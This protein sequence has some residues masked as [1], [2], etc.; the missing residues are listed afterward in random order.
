M[1]AIVIVL[2]FVALSAVG[3]YAASEEP[4]ESA[5]MAS[6]DWGCTG[7]LAV[8]PPSSTPVTVS[9]RLNEDGMVASARLDWT[10]ST[11]GEYSLAVNL[12]S[13]SGSLHISEAGS[14]F[15]TDVIDVYPPVSAR[16]ADLARVSIAQRLDQATDLALSMGWIFNPSGQVTAA[17]VMWEPEPG[18][19]YELQVT[20]GNGSGSAVVQGPGAV[21]RTDTIALS[22]PVSPESASSANLCINKI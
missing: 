13:G 3:V 8:N 20:L 18:S 12:G 16:S 6:G 14:I 5:G 9:W 10:P 19:D 22:P 1:R 2:L 4:A 7:N 17:E 11:Y 21:T 15:R